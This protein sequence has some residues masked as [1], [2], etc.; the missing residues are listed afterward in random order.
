MLAASEHKNIAAEAISP[1]KEN[2]PK[3]MVDKNLDLISGVSSPKN[4]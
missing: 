3:G 1:G 4:D 2:L